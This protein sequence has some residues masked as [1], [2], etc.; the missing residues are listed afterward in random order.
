M[1]FRVFD[2]E[3]KEFVDS[4]P[5]LLSSGGTLIEFDE[6]YGTRTVFGRFIPIFSTTQKDV[7]GNEIYEGDVLKD[8]IGKIGFVEYNKMA[9]GWRCFNFKNRKSKMHHFHHFKII[10]SIYTNPELLEKG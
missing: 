1:K 10:G 6:A 5:F 9:K 2:K 4:D 8:K 3:K 7:D